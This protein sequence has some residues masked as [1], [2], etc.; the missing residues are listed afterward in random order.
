MDVST[1]DSDRRR[2]ASP[3]SFSKPPAV[4][5][6]GAP[7]GT[8]GREVSFMRKMD[9]VK[10]H[11]MYAVREEVE[12]LKQQIG[13]M[14][15][16]IGQLEYENT[17]LKS[18]AKPETLSKLLLPRVT[19]AA[20]QQ[21]LPSGGAS[22]GAGGVPTSAGVASQ[23]QQSNVVVAQT[24][25]PPTP[26]G[27]QTTIAMLPPQQAQTIS[28]GTSTPTPQHM[29]QQQQQQHLHQTSTSQPGQT[30]MS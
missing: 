30:P 19:Q 13:E 10:R 17:V 9:L 25:K 21:I 3:G 11:L 16:R 26:N 28:S 6:G 23:Q 20:S 22:G 29:Q 7:C 5:A 18:E 12:I 8:K 15:E 2:D 24:Q 27:Q 14:M 4:M 1:P